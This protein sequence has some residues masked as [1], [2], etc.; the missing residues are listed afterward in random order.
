[1][2][3]PVNQHLYLSEDQGDGRFYRYVPDAKNAQG[4]ADLTSGKLEVAELAADGKVT[5]HEVP[6]PQFTGAT[7]T[8]AQVAA[9]T[10]FKGG[11]GL[12]YHAGLIFLSTK[13]DNKIWAYDIKAQTMKVLYDQATARTRSCRESTTLP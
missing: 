10:A 7:P 6:D 9:S 1:M 13:G 5:W 4:F 12:A 8:R 2:L 3:D 11:E